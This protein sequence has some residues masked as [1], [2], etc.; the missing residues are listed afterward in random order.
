VNNLF[1]PESFKKILTA[2]PAFVS[3]LY[4]AFNAA[5]T[6]RSFFV[7]SVKAPC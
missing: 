7:F 1:A 3:C 5:L 6:G 2:K 4:P